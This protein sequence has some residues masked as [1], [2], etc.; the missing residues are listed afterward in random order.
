MNKHRTGV[1]P[2]FLAKHKLALSGL[3]ATNVKS[4]SAEIDKL[5]AV[6]GVLINEQ[7]QTIKI[8]YDASHHDIDEMIEII[9]KH[10]A[11]ID[12]SW[13]TRYKLGWQRQTDQNIK[14]NSMH[15]ASCCNKAPT[16]YKTPK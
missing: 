2:G 12:D 4:I 15:V 16:N 1:N 13:W 6:D 7:K 14:D 8:A 11:E 9:R 10:D 5:W 3:N